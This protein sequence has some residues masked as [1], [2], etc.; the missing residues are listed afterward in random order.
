MVSRTINDQTLAS[1]IDYVIFDIK[2]LLFE[3]GGGTC[4]FASLKGNVVAHTLA[5]G[6]V[7]FA[8]NM[9]WLSECPP[10]IY[11]CIISDALLIQ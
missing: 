6:S 9:A 3:L 2:S 4:H 8:G 10:S 1:V 7:S 11:N 5:R